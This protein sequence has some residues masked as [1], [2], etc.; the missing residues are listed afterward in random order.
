[1]NHAIEK[2]SGGLT[3]APNDL[4]KAMAAAQARI[5]KVYAGGCTTLIDKISQADW[6]E[7]DASDELGIIGDPTPLDQ[8]DPADLDDT[9]QA[10]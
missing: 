3:L 2:T 10:A 9:E 6:N 7:W 1:M 5:E 4:E 8:V